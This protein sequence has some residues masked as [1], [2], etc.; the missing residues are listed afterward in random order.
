MIGI[1]GF[2]SNFVYQCPGRLSKSEARLHI[3]VVKDQF[4]GSDLAKSNPRRGGRR[5]TT[6]L[7]KGLGLTANLNE[8]DL[9]ASPY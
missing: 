8:T 1:L 9:A 3:S 2:L 7:G 4:Q 6:S 5:R